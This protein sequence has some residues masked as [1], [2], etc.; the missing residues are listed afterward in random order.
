M[1][2]AADLTLCVVAPVSASPDAGAI[3]GA[4]AAGLAVGGAVGAGAVAYSTPFAS[5]KKEGDE[6][7]APV[8]PAPTEVSAWISSPFPQKTLLAVINVEGLAG[9]PVRNHDTELCKFECC[10]HMPFVDQPSI[11]DKVFVL[12]VASLSAVPCGLC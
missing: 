4:T 12:S 10:T 1:S 3:A 11:G 2:Q 8:T 9:L 7:E 6:V 5:P